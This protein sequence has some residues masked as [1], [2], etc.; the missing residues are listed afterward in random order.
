MSAHRRSIYEAAGSHNRNRETRGRNDITEW[1]RARPLGMLSQGWGSKVSYR[2]LKC[3]SV[4]NGSEL[5]GNL[6]AGGS[7]DRGKKV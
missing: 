5:D 4:H 2:E 7:P 3:F 6:P 1:L